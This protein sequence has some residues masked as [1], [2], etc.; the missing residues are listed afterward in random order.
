VRYGCS[1]PHTAEVRPVTTILALFLAGYVVACIL[2]FLF[3][4]RL[5]YYPESELVATPAGIGLGFRDVFFTTDDGVT[6]HGWYVPATPTADPTPQDDSGEPP[7]ILFCHGNAGNISG[8]L[9]LIQL[10]H[11][12]GLAIFIFDYRGYGKSLGKPDEVGTYRD[13]LAAWHHL[14]DVERVPPDRIIL[15]GRSIGSAV[16]I[17]LATRVSPRALIV[18]SGFTSAVD[19]GARVYWWLPVKLLARVRYDSAARV[20]TLTLP[21]LFIHSRADDVV[22]FSMGRRLFET[23]AEPKRFLEIRGGHND[24]FLVSESEYREG[25][26]EFLERL[27]VAEN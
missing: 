19:L 14:T 22:P 17:E 1:K 3:Q 18:D 24:G 12:L 26:E 27:E 16:A 11:E 4:S 15:C 20:R 2:V 5:V 25:I 23:A 9:G 21:K 7:V 6:L 8:R 13:A 10:F